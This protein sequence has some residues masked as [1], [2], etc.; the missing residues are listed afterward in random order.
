MEIK[1]IWKR[2]PLK[3]KKMEE[4]FRNC[5]TCPSV[6]VWSKAYRD[7]YCGTPESQFT[8]I[9]V[10]LRTPTNPHAFQVL[11]ATLDHFLI[12]KS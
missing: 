9:Q 1:Y 4:N 12:P 8:G 3:K 5:R 10:I 2:K 6:L 11:G 7:T